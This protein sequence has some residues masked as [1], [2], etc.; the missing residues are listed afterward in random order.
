MQNEAVRC[1][2]FQLKKGL[3]MYMIAVL[4]EHAHVKGKRRVWPSQNSAFSQQKL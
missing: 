1:D 2:V 3:G 4:K